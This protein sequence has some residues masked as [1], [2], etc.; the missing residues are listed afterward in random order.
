[1]AQLPIASDFQ[2]I[3]NRLLPNCVCLRAPQV[4]KLGSHTYPP[5]PPQ[6]HF[7][8]RIDALG[9]TNCKH[10]PVGL[11]YCNVLRSWVVL[12]LAVMGGRN[13]HSTSSSEQNSMRNVQRKTSVETPVVIRGR[14]HVQGHAQGH[15]PDQGQ[16]H[17]PLDPAGEGG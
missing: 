5:P 3:F 15:A 12:L 17:R 1:M 8:S 6:F 7:L 10:R 16:D 11:F 2:P 9:R 13:W 4:E 14:G